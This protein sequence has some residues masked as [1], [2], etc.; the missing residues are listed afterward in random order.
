MIR[1]CKLE[2]DDVKWI[3]KNLYPVFIWKM[4]TL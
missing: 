1:N 4:E 2:R 3:T